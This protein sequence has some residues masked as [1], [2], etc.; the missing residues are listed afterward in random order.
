MGFRFFRRIRLAPG[1]TLNLSRSGGSLS[2]GPR[3]AKITLGPRG[4]R[5]TLGLP[6]TGL[7]YTENRSWSGGK[8]Q[9]R[10][11]PRIETS[12]EARLD[13]G[14]F[15]RLVTPDDEEGFVDGMRALVHGDEA[16]ARERLRSARELADGAFIGGLLALKAGDLA[17]AETLFEVA[18]SRSAELGTLFDKYGLAARAL[19]A[20]SEEVRAVIGADRRGVLLARAELAQMKER[21]G[22]ALPLLDELLRAH[23]QDALVRLSLAELLVEEQGDPASLD[24]VVRLT[25]GIE[26]VS[27]LHAGLLLYKGRA[28]A[29]LGMYKAARD[30]LTTGLR[31]R[32]ER[33]AELL[34]ALRYER[35]L[36]Y[37]VLGRAARMRE[38]LGRV[39]AE[40]PDYED[41]AARL[42]L[43][44]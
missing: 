37:G 32:R 33:P 29:R 22:A 27:A 1:L 2:L 28:L 41:V 24:Y 19:L 4:V 25:E 26:N 10:A 15:R 6:G 31:R 9:R 11:A 12:P 16:L 21:P 39:Y 23:P 8:R 38:E 5:R 14:F 44:R 34:I 18:D 30:A 7:Y 20:V 36:V 42:G 3:G 13:L 17:E 40:D 43:S 35:A